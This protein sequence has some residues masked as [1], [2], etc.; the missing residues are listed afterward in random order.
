MIS[1]STYV[2][3]V[4]FT[5]D[6]VRFG[7]VR[8]LSPYIVKIKTVNRS[9]WSHTLNEIGVGRIKTV[10]FSSAYDP[11]KTTLYYRSRKRKLNHNKPT[12]MLLSRP[13]KVQIMGDKENVVEVEEQLVFWLRSTDHYF[14]QGE[15]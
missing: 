7:V 4:V 13:A 2:L 3:R 14:S 5:G 6:E 12:K 10:L 8:A 1:T 15:A 9:Q 11:V